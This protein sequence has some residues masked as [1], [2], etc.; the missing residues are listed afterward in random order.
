M[1]RDQAKGEEVDRIMNEI[2]G[3]YVEEV[4]TPVTSKPE[5]TPQITPSC[6]TT[7]N[8]SGIYSDI[9]LSIL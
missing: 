3:G 9:W 5:V 7:S 1:L 2:Q 8:E 4:A 6:T